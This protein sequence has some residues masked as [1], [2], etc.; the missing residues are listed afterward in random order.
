MIR[1]Y[2]L[3]RPADGEDMN[4]FYD[5]VMSLDKTKL[6]VNAAQAFT[7]GSYTKVAEVET[8]DLE[9]AWELTNNLASSWSRDPHASVTVTTPLPVVDGKT[10]GLRSSMV[11]DVMIKDGI[12]YVAASFGFEEAFR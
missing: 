11:G 12:G 10:W 1:V 9:V 2:H 6:T 5:I 3:N 7:L 8:D 4:A